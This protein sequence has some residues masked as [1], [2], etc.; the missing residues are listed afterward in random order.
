MSHSVIQN[1][2]A[3][4]TE[5]RPARWAKSDEVCRHLHI[6]RA[7]FYRYVEAGLIPQPTRLGRCG[8][9]DLNEIDKALR[10][11]RAKRAGAA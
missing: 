8:R 1:D 2:P 7:T 11:A 4:P 3:A 6:S 9:W 10:D 5:P